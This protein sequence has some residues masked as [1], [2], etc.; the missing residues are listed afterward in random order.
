LHL[1]AQQYL[2]DSA[3]LKTRL[4]IAAVQRIV[5]PRVRSPWHW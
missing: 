1:N 3:L 4:L 5:T 2:P